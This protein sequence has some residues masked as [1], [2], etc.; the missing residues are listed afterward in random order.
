MKFT[1][2]TTMAVAALASATLLGGTVAAH[3]AGIVAVGGDATDRDVAFEAT[4]GG[5]YFDTDYG[6]EVLCEENTS[7]GTVAAGSAVPDSGILSVTPPA[8][9]CVLRGIFNLPAT[10][11][12]NGTWEFSATGPA[13]NGVAPGVVND[14]ELRVE[15]DLTG[16][17]KFTATGDMRAE[18]DGA[19]Q[20]LRL[21]AEPLVEYPLSITD[22]SGCLSFVQ[23]G[24]GG[25]Y[26]ADYDVTTDEGAIT[27]Q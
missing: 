8:G 6:I 1:F 11:T 25:Q 27:F 10:M 2:K 13:V 21:V 22:A 18:F 23:D 7:T 20:R 9:N 17:C 24:D 16:F 12:Y 3:A 19:S 5:I 4:S 14:V 15:S 26:V